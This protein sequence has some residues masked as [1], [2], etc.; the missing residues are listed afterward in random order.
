MRAFG[1]TLAA[2]LAAS[3]PCAG[4]AQLFGLHET[5]GGGSDTDGSV[6]PSDVSVEMQLISIGPT[7]AR[8]PYDV[9]SLAANFLVADGSTAAGVKRVKATATGDLWSAAI[10]DGKPPV[11]INLGLDLPDLF[12]RLYSVQQRNLKVLYGIYG[13]IDDVAAPAT[14]SLTVTLNLPSPSAANEGI[15]L[16]N[17]GGWANHGFAGGTDYTVGAQTIGPIA[18]PYTPATWGSIS[19]RPLAQITAADEIVG[20]RYVGNQLTGAAEFTPFAQSTTGANTLTATMTAVTAAP[21]DVHVSPT[22]ID[23]RLAMPTPKGQTLAM[24]WSVNAAPGWEIANGTGPQLNAAGILLTD[25]GA[26][27]APFGNP[28]AAKGWKSVFTLGTTKRRT[29]AVPSLGNLVGTFYCG[30]NEIAEV[31]PGLTIDTP[32]ALPIV[33][34]INSMPLAT[35]GQ[36]VALD[37]T[38]SVQL[39]ILAD[40]TDA[41]FYQFNIYELRENA[42][43][44]ALETHVAYV[45]VSDQAM[46]TIPNDVFVAGKTYFIRGHA[47][48]G[49]YPSFSEGNFWT[50]NLPY[51][52]GYLDAGVFTVSAP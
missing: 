21:L 14:G 47:I 24:S 41:L 20:L 5:T 36:N 11:E 31:A 19:G 51:S 17:V 4:C 33:V 9:T 43:M 26:I 42:A 32:A 7:A 28:F 45:A 10:P 22:N 18:V 23:Q 52:V 25:T 49:G 37:P 12:R 2:A 29:F 38:K 16:Y 15:Q 35:D 1:A 44:T 13:H 50:R 27:A 40:K 39:A 48:K 8:T 3:F 6:P 46:V 30:L 34:S